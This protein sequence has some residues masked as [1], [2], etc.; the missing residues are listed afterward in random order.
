VNDKLHKVQ[1]LLNLLASFMAI[2]AVVYGAL[3]AI[4]V[5]IP[6]PVKNNRAIV[7]LRVDLNALI[8]AVA[9]E[10]RANERFQRTLLAVTC[11]RL[12]DAQSDLIPECT[13]YR[14]R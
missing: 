7:A 10:K 12:S 4:G 11:T 9:E 2:A 3:I 13:T 6:T 5:D 1:N 8:G 14:R